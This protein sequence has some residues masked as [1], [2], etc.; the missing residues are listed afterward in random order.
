[1]RIPNES[2]GM[3]G[4][5]LVARDGFDE[6][7]SITPD[8]LPGTAGSRSCRMIAGK[9]AAMDLWNERS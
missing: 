3:R 9:Y 1:V 6:L 7:A 4:D 5:S 8:A 2:L